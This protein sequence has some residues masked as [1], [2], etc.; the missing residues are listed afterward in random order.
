MLVNS[1]VE[2]CYTYS[3]SFKHI[4]Q[5]TIERASQG[6]VVLNLRSKSSNKDIMYLHVDNSIFVIN[7]SEVSSRKTICIRLN[8]VANNYSNNSF[9]INYISHTFA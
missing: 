9:F 3:H 5:R 2:I 1:I 7:F 8:C 6:R 4:S